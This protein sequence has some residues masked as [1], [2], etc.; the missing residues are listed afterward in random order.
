MTTTMVV[1]STNN[2]RLNAE[3]TANKLKLD[4]DAGTTYKLDYVRFVVKSGAVLRVEV[5]V[6][7]TGDRTQV[8]N[9]RG[10][11]GSIIARGDPVVSSSGKIGI[12]GASKHSLEA[13]TLR[14]Q[15]S[16][17]HADFFVSRA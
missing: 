4:G 7:F 16:F 9:G 15:S 12:G 13:P 11:P 1:V 3:I 6:E 10:I 2:A 17:P 5:E 14:G 8:R